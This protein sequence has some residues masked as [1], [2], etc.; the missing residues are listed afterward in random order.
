MIEWEVL[1]HIRERV[2]ASSQEEWKSGR[3]DNVPDS[4]RADIPQYDEPMEVDKEQPKRK[5]RPDKAV[6]VKR[7][8]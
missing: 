8:V 1:L 4:W 3:D 6:K 2:G 7:E 5:R